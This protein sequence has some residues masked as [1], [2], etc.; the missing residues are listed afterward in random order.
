MAVYSH[1]FLLYQYSSTQIFKNSV[2]VPN[3]FFKNDREAKGKMLKEKFKIWRNKT[4]M[5]LHY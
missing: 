2:W 3:Y 1:I 4:G 5:D